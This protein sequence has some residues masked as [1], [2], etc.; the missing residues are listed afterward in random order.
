M[1]KELR[2]KTEDQLITIAMSK[3]D[4]VVAKAARS[5][6]IAERTLW[7]KIKQRLENDN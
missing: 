1:L 3:S 2:E 5:L 7:R 4:G 6:G